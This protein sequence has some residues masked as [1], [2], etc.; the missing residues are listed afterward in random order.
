MDSYS[1]SELAKHVRDQHLHTT[2]NNLFCPIISILALNWR[3]KAFRSI[4]ITLINLPTKHF[5]D[6]II[7]SYFFVCIVKQ[8]GYQQRYFNAYLRAWKVVKSIEGIVDKIWIIFP[9][10]TDFVWSWIWMHH[11]QLNSWV[12]FKI[13]HE[14]ENSFKKDVLH[15]AYMNILMTVVT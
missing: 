4:L 9:T 13:E 1:C 11:S 14:T 6:I 7:E 10:G 8:T 15:W 3:N 2:L 12:H 5:C